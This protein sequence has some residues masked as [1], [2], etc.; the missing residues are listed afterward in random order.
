MGVLA[1]TLCC[2]QSLRTGMQELRFRAVGKAGGICTCIQ[3]VET[4]RAP[5]PPSGAGDTAANQGGDASPGPSTKVRL[6]VVLGGHRRRAAL[7][8]RVVPEVISRL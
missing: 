1:S 6:Q 2:V 7:L 4:L 8:G 5:E 3:P